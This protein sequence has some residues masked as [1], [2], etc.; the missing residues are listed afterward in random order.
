[1]EDGVLLAQQLLL[2]VKKQVDLFH[3]QEARKNCAALSLSLK[4]VNATLK[5]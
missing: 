1:M 5:N 2:K 4:S 3:F